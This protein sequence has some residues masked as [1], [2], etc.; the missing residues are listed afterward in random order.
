MRSLI[1]DDDETCRKFLTKALEKHGRCDLAVTGAEAVKAVAKAFQVGELY[2]AIFLD[3]MMPVM[4]GRRALGAI[5]DLEERAGLMQG[6]G[7]KIIMTTAIGDYDS[8]RNAFH[9]QCDGYL[10]KP[11]KLNRLEALMSNLNLIP[12]AQ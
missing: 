9:N 1:V 12:K 11:L 8:V 10:V 4:D 7:A 6:W 5:R 2:D 3:I